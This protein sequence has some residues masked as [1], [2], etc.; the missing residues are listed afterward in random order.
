[1]VTINESTNVI[2][3]NTND[4]SLAKTTTVIEYKVSLESYSMISKTFIIYVNLLSSDSD[5][6]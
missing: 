5:E 2:T 3:I 6:L 4:S 1:M